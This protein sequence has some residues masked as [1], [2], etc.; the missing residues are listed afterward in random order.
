[1][2]ALA[3][4]VIILMSGCARLY[5]HRRYDVSDEKTAVQEALKR[6]HNARVRNVHVAVK[7]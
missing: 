1:M 7:R 5:V 3:L 4:L 6:N 2:V